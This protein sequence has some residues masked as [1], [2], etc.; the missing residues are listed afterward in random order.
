MNSKS[1]A[2]WTHTRNWCMANPFK[3][4]AIVT[5][6][7]NFEITFKPKEQ[8]PQYFDEMGDITPELL[9]ALESRLK[10]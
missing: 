2:I 6:Q 9:A 3:K 5:L 10:K 1:R 4:A 7:G 8:E